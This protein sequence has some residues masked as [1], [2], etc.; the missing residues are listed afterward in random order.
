M[1]TNP[2]KA[3][4]AKWFC[5]YYKNQDSIDDVLSL[6]E[7]ATTRGASLEAMFYGY[8]ILL[9]DIF[10]GAAADED[11]RDFGDVINKHIEQFHGLILDH[12]QPIFIPRDIC[13][14]HRIALQEMATGALKLE[15]EKKDTNQLVFISLMVCRNDVF[16]SGLTDAETKEM[17]SMI[18]DGE[19]VLRAQT[20]A[21]FFE[22]TFGSDPI[23]YFN[24][25]NEKRKVEAAGPD[26]KR[27]RF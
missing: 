26:A 25:R 20:D 19:R 17:E 8:M 22:E 1:E 12:K 14:H 23:T 4:V 6:Y 24:K 15:L 16:T 7:K 21:A 3:E 9:G 5:K 27:V 18:D 11:G 10:D 13:H 2:T